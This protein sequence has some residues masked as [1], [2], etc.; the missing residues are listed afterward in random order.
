MYRRNRY[1][2]T[3]AQRVERSSVAEHAALFYRNDARLKRPPGTVSK[4]LH[5]TLTP[6]LI[7]AERSTCRNKCC[8]GMTKPAFNPKPCNMYARVWAHAYTDAHAHEYKREAI[9]RNW[10]EIAVDTVVFA[11]QYITWSSGLI[12]GE[13]NEGASYKRNEY[14]FNRTIVIWC[15]SP[16]TDTIVQTLCSEC[17][18]ECCCPQFVFV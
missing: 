9:D 18:E 7:S 14:T 5:S 12:W 3:E 10:Y 1:M 13:T 8:H 11:K 15:V 4:T 16:P 2:L 17:N 6:P